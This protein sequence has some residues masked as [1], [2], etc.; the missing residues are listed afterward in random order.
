MLATF[1]STTENGF[2][3]NAL[4]HR[5]NATPIGQGEKVGVP[6]WF[7]HFFTTTADSE[8]TRYVLFFDM[9]YSESLDRGPASGS[10]RK[11]H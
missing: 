5:P 10:V 9:V 11:G 1:D 3:E 6:D 4:S 7:E 8:P 2:D